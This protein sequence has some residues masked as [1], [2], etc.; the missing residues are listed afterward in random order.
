V[1][2]YADDPALLAAVQELPAGACPL[3]TSIEAVRIRASRE[4]PWETRE[5]VDGSPEDSALAKLMLRALDDVSVHDLVDLTSRRRVFRHLEPCLLCQH[6]N[7]PGPRVY[8][9]WHTDAEE[10][11]E[12]EQGWREPDPRRLVE[13]PNTAAAKQWAET[14]AQFFRD[15]VERALGGRVQMLAWTVPADPGQLPGHRLLTAAAGSE[16]W[17]WTARPAGPAEMRYPDRVLALHRD[18][19]VASR[20]GR[21]AAAL[22]PP[23]GPPA[24]PASSFRTERA[25]DGRC[26]TWYD[27]GGKGLLVSVLDPRSSRPAVRFTSNGEKP[28]DGAPQ[29]LRVFGSHLGDRP[30]LTTVA[31]QAPGFTDLLPKRQPTSRGTS[32]PRR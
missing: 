21:E 6:R 12:W 9:V 8:A 19:A 7:A 26:L 23:L 2:E 10:A 14:T 11:A 24:A 27:D 20:D 28:L 29:G 22:R 25:P 4:E 31:Q 15:R 17:L 3:L 1:T 13:L 5:I 18:G 30:P 32:R 16:L